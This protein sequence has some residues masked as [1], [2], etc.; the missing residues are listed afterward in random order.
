MKN[1]YKIKMHTIIILL[2]NKYN[3]FKLI[4]KI[5]NDNKSKNYKNGDIEK[6]YIFKIKEVNQLE[7]LKENITYPNNQELILLNLK[8]DN[9]LEEILKNIHS[10]NFLNR[11]NIKII[12]LNNKSQLIK[13][14]SQLIKNKTLNEFKILK[15]DYLHLKKFSS[16]N[17]KVTNI[18]EYKKNILNKN[19]EWIVIGDVHGSITELKELI[20]KIGFNIKDN[21][22]I[23]TIKTKKI[24]LILAGDLVDKSN[25]KDITDTIDFIYLNLKN[26]NIKDKIKVIKGNHELR[27]YDWIKKT[28]NL[29]ITE[30]TIK[31]KKEYYNTTFI[32]EQNYE[33]KN[34]FLFIYKKM[35]TFVK[36]IDLQNKHS[37]IV[38][39]APCEIQYLEKLD[40]LSQMKNIKSKSRSKNKNL[41]NDDLTMYLKVESNINHPLHIFGHLGQEEVRRYNNKICIDTG[42]V[43]GN[44]LT[45]LNTI[46]KEFYEINSIKART[47]KKYNNKLFNYKK[48]K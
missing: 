22:I 17:I 24:G 18:K 36:Y 48:E 45:G 34:K 16:F 27:V 6:N 9:T 19:I 26:K 31:E 41:T 2:G 33:L 38:T 20:K 11:Y 21:L 35:S 12:D 15:K 46:S 37:F 47:D 3:K 44:V 42:C 40:K 23:D 25:E 4:K 14:K 7:N 32:L 5:L 29:K 43:Y 10:E 39:H 13:K 28:A 8:E 30:K 1:S